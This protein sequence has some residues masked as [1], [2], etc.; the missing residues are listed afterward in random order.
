MSQYNTKSRTAHEI[1]QCGYYL[2]KQH[3]KPASAVKKIL[4]I[5]H[6]RHLLFS[7]FLSR[8]LWPKDRTCLLLW[9]SEKIAANWKFE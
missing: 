7:P 2:W 8:Q 5:C 1:C 3:F 9:V 4:K 6:P